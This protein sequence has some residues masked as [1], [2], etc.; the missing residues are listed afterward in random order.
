MMNT[1]FLTRVIDLM[2][3]KDFPIPSYVGQ[4][5]K[6]ASCDLTSKSGVWYS[7]VDSFADDKLTFRSRD[8]QTGEIILAAERYG[9]LDDIKEAAY[10]VD[11]I[12]K[13]AKEI[14]SVKEWQDTR[15]WAM[16]QAAFMDSEMKV[17]IGQYLTEKCGELN[18]VPSFSEK[19]TLDLLCENI[20]PEVQE[21]IEK[22]ASDEL[23]SFGRDIYLKADLR[24]MSAA[25]LR[26]VFPLEYKSASLIADEFNDA[27]FLKQAE[28]FDENQQKVLKQ[29]LGING[30][31][32]VYSGKFVPYEISDDI[33]AAL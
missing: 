19:L 7:A 22:Q 30:I 33:L 9:I 26:E 3:D 25:D 12:G 27:L 13:D 18:Y 16:K 21:H 10:F 23:V 28:S 2:R 14:R 1:E 6:S 24:K 32:P 20:S 5:E 17:S 11:N 8:K 31:R 4:T 29:M 15:H